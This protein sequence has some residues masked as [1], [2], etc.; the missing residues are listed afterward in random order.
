MGAG[1][2]GKKGEWVEEGAARTSSLAHLSLKPLGVFCAFSFF[3]TT[4]C[5]PQSEGKARQRIDPVLGHSQRESRGRKE[6]IHQSEKKEE[7]F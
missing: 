3:L 4:P 5:L 2:G 6:L 1:R 7:G